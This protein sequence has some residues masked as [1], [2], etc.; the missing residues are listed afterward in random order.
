MI[1]AD[2]KTPQTD[3]VITGGALMALVFVV[4]YFAGGAQW[5]K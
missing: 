4:A 3:A 2:R 5:M 1:L